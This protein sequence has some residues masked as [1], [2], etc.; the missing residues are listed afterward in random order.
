MS[1]SKPMNHASVFSSTVPV[2]P[3][4]GHSLASPAAAAPVPRTSDAAQQVR[5][6]ERRVGADHVARLGA[7]LLEQV[8][9]AI[10]H[11]Q[12]VER[13]HPHALIRERR[14]GARHLEQR[15][16]AGAE[17]DRQVGREVFL[18]AEALRVVEHVLRPERV[19]HLDR[20]DVARLLERPAKRDRRLRT[21]DRSCAGCR[22]ARWPADS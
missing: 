9:V 19:H 16:V 4:S 22:P 7:V 5:H 17:R 10:L 1:G 11:R 6:H 2:L 18:E 20:R 8:A 13:L 21:C 3:A 15:P 14:V 12:H